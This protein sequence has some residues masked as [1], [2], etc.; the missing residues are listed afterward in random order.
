LLCQLSY[1]SLRHWRDSNP[2]P[3]YEVTRAFT[4]LQTFCG[5]NHRPR[6]LSAALSIELRQL[7]PPAGVEPATVGSRCNPCL[8]HAANSRILTSLLHSSRMHTRSTYSPTS[9]RFVDSLSRKVPGELALTVKLHSRLES[10]V[11]SRGPRSSRELH[12][13][14]TQIPQWNELDRNDLGVFFRVAR[15]SSPRDPVALVSFRLGFCLRVSN[16]PLHAQ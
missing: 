10:A 13:P 12:H 1:S 9:H 6:Y 3:L 2:Q 7:A 4:T 8:H 14:G 5:G 16:L 15:T 11:C